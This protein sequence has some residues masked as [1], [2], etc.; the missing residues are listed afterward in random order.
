MSKTLVLL[1]GGMDSCVLLK[2]LMMEQKHE[3]VCL[4][5]N[6][7]QS[8]LLREQ[9]SAARVAKAASVTYETIDVSSWRRGCQ[10][11]FKDWLQVPRNAIFSH[12]SLP[13]AIANGCDTLAVGSTPEDSKVSDSN[14]AFFEELNHFWQHLGL[15]IRAVA[16]FLKAGMGKEQIIRWSDENLGLEFVDQTTSCWKSITCSESKRAPCPACVKRDL[17]LTSARPA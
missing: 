3:C 10:D 14:Q 1:S 8:S 11:R 12:L 6:W 15:T 7:S 16:P 17:A 2:W 9:A 13:Y 4:F 5:I